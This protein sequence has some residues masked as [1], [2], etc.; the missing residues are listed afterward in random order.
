[1]TTTAQRYNTIAKR[2]L[3]TITKKG[4]TCTLIADAWKSGDI[5]A[6]IAAKAIEIPG[7]PDTYQALNLVAMNP[8]T[9]LIAAYGLTAR[10]KAGVQFRWG[11]EIYT[12]KLATPLVPDGETFILW[13]LVGVV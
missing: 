10:L 1:M 4:A 11:G 7:D 2:A 8:V 3:A 6:D 13:T 12:T 5:A 9:L